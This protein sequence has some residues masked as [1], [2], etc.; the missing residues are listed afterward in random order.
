MT[1]RNFISGQSLEAVILGSL[2]TLGMLALQIPYAPM[3][4]ALVGVTALIPVVGAFI[5]TIVGAFM[6]LTV[7]PVKAVIFV[8]FFLILQ[9]IEGNLI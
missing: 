5:G 4:G 7:E 6:I 1:F 3:V 8:I 9:Q 2:C